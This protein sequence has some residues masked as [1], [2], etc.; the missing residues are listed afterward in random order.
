MKGPREE[1]H[2]VPVYVCTG[3]GFFPIYR[4]AGFYILFL[5]KALIGGEFG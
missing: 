3:S 1:S 5:K 4:N 2:Q